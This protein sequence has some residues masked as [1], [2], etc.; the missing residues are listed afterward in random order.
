MIIEKYLE[1]IYTLRN[2]Q[3]SYIIIKNIF[4]VNKKTLNFVL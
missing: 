4:R 2:I 3:G 1:S